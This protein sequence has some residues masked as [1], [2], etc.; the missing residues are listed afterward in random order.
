M[1]SAGVCGLPSDFSGDVAAACLDF[2]GWAS[3]RRRRP[4]GKSRQSGVRARHRHRI[5]R[6][7]GSH[8]PVEQAFRRNRALASSSSSSLDLPLNKAANSPVCPFTKHR[9]RVSQR[10]ARARLIAFQRVA[11]DGTCTVRR[12]EHLAELIMRHSRPVPNAAGIEMDEGR[13]RCRIE[14]DAAALQAKPAK[15]ICSSGTSGM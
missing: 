4:A 5:G 15:R 12:R 3:A 8:Q 14:P 13:S 11:S 7:G 10:P 2:A 9:R 1:I 6:F